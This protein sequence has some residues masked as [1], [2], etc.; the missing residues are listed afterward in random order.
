MRIKTTHPI[1]DTNKN[2]SI[3]IPAG[4]IFDAPDKKA[5]EWIEKEWAFEISAET[6]EVVTPRKRRKQ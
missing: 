3:T 2:E 5:R 6:T 1:I 4:I